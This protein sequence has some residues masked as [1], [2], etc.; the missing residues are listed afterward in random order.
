[1][2]KL[3]LHVVSQERE[4]IQTT[5]ESVTAMTIEGEVT[6]LPGHIPLFTKLA[7]GELRFS[8]NKKE[9]SLVV[10]QGFLTV[11]QDNS[12]I[13]M[14]DTAVLAREVSEQKAQQ[15]I[16]QAHETMRLSQDKRELLMAEASLR[17]AM[18]ELKV[19]Q[20]SRRTQY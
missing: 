11:G 19:A 15:A 9:E 16:K 12:V 20:K 14:V 17:L 5:V 1:M 13:I 2:A 18:L 4:L 8:S 6:I 3:Q 7:A 10:S